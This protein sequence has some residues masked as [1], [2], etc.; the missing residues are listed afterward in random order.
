MVDQHSEALDHQLQLR[1]L[2]TALERI[3]HINCD[4]RA[5]SPTVFDAVSVPAMSVHCYLV[6]LHRYTKFDFVCFHVA[7]WY[8]HQLCLTDPAYCPTLHN[9]HRLLVAALLVSSKATDGERPFPFNSSSLKASNV[10]RVVAPRAYDP[11]TSGTSAPASHTPSCRFRFRFR[12]RFADIFHANLFMAQCGGIGV[13][14]LNKLEVDLCERLKWKLLPTTKE[15]GELLEAVYNPQAAFWNGWYNARG[16]DVAQT[17]LMATALDAPSQ[18]PQQHEQQAQRSENHTPRMPHAKS[19]HE[20]LSRLFRGGAS[21]GN[22]EAM[23]AAQAAAG[24]APSGGGKQQQQQQH[25]GAVVD[26]HHVH[27]G[28]SNTSP[29]SVMGKTF[30]FSNLFGL[31]TGW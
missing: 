30:S 4:L 12:F 15:M 13:G 9:I 26:L 3:C 28:R 1:A 18:S 8:L 21:E 7:T 11:C 20:S 22:L 23:A 24:A 14:E 31:A 10:C 19:V 2:A 27:G 29:R 25:D 17:P 5:T 6:R 16:T